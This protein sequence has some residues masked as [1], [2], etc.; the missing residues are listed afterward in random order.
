MLLIAIFSSVIW[1][2]GRK[3]IMAI[4]T[5]V[6]VGLFI[7][8]L[9]EFSNIKDFSKKSEDWK[10]S[11]YWH[12]G[13]VITGIGAVGFGK[14]YSSFIASLIGM[15]VSVV[16]CLKYPGMYDWMDKLVLTSTGLVF[17]CEYYWKAYKS[18]RLQ[19]YQ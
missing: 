15:G 3:F 6:A 4:A 14:P 19:S 10:I 5:V 1:D 11:L 9:Y 12:A 7:F 13:F 8:H 17:L 2:A 16:V 18:C